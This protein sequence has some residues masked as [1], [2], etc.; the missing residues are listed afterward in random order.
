ME[1]SDLLTSI[2]KEI[3]DYNTDEPE[4]ETK[5]KKNRKKIN[6][7]ERYYY[8]FDYPEL[9]EWGLI[10]ISAE[11]IILQFPEKKSDVI[12]NSFKNYKHFNLI[13]NNQVRF[14]LQWLPIYTV[15]DFHKTKDM[16]YKCYSEFY[17]KIFPNKISSQIHD[18]N[19]VHYNSQYTHHT[20]ENCKIT[21]L[22]DS[23][24]T[25][26]EIVFENQSQSHLIDKVSKC[27]HLKFKIYIGKHLILCNDK[28]FSNNLSYSSNINFLT[29]F[30][31]QK[32]F[33]I[34]F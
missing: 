10:A 14:D 30:I 26:I 23:S 32:L 17:K 25:N 8:H 13:I 18:F 34:Y 33:S 11:Q 20:F 12:P 24:L 31:L 1:S 19:P 5:K 6:T 15:N 29:Y 3:E 28:D 22:E 2:R 7:L 27:Q 16:I 9:S 21:C 4:T